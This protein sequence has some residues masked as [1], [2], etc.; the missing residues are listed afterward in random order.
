MP[1]SVVQQLTGVY[2]AESPKEFMRRQAL[3]KP[4]VVV[5]TGHPAPVK[6]IR[7]PVVWLSDLVSV[8][9]GDIPGVRLRGET[10]PPTPEGFTEEQWDYTLEVI[11]YALNEGPDFSGTHQYDADEDLADEEAPLE[12]DGGICFTP[13]FSWLYV[14]GQAAY[15]RHRDGSYDAPSWRDL[16]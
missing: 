8:G 6:T 10:A 3:A 4:H 2:E 13:S 14:G 15:E 5:T 11:E 16:V 1:S 12:D 9:G 7:V